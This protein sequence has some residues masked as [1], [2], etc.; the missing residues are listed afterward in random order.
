ML[1]RVAG[2]SEYPDIVTLRAHWPKHDASE[3]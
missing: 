2:I 1:A 3:R